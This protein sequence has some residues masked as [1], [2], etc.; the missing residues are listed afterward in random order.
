MLYKK[1]WDE[2]KTKWRNYWQRKNEGRPLMCVIAQKEHDK[3]KAGALLSKNVQEKYFD[4]QKRVERYRHFCENHEFLAESFPNINPD[5]GPGSM[6][7]YL[8]C[9]T[10]FDMNTVWYEDFIKD[11][12]DI[13]KL[14]FDPENKYFKKHTQLY[15]D[16]KAL[17]GED[18][19]LCIPDIIE[20]L[21]ILAS[22]RGG[23]NLI[24]DMIDEPEEISRR[25][26]ELDDIYFDYYNSFYDIV[27]YEGNS[28]AYT[29]FQIWGEGRTA[30]LQCDFSAVMSPGQFRDFVQESLRKQAK[31]L[32]N[33]LYHLDG[34]DAVKHLDAILE[35]DEIDA[36]QWTSGSY[37]P[38]GS[39]EEWFDIYDKAVRAGKG[40]WVH[41]YSGSLDEQIKRLDKL[42]ERYGSKALFM[43]FAPMPEENAQRLLEHAE[44]HW[45]S[46]MGNIYK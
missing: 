21:D 37:N 32:D 5:F 13:G 33:V 9:N 4:P 42:V 44:K 24:Y 15:R 20:N 41:I 22:M 8:G 23:Q 45:N 36:L 11:W 12:K 10:I 30:K 40:L 29:T 31:R 26:A 43:Y 2:T 34:P 1:N 27:K 7:S 46:V 14:E 16:I 6:A 17:I 35:I 3:E 19:I 25:I 39:F 28:S 38:D 18:V